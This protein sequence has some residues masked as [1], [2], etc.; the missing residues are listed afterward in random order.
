MSLQTTALLR[1]LRFGRQTTG[2]LPLSPNMDGCGPYGLEFMLLI[3]VSSASK[4]SEKKL[5]PIKPW[6]SQQ[7]QSLTEEHFF[8]RREIVP[9]TTAFF[10]VESVKSTILLTA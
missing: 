10:D 2:S 8:N 1:G 9:M 7:R 4:N 5:S 6:S 3:S